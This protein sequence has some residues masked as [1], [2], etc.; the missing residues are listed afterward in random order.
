MAGGGLEEA[1]RRRERMPRAGGGDDGGVTIDI[2]DWTGCGFFLEWLGV[3]SSDNKSLRWPC[4]L[5]PW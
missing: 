2:V 3:A 4:G 5:P 1:D